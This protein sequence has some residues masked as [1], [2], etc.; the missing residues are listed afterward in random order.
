MKVASMVLGARHFSFE[1]GD[2]RVIKCVSG[3]LVP[4]KETS[5]KDTIHYTRSYTDTHTSGRLQATGLL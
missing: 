4:K 3:L 5:C 2:T 1:L